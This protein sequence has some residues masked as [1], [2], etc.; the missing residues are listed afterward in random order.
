MKKCCVFLAEGFEET[1]AVA[2]IDIL[3]RGGISVEIVSITGKIEVCGAHQIT[4]LA[5]S[6]FAEASFDDADMLILPGGM[7]GA[8]NLSNF[9]PLKQLLVQFNLYQ[10]A[11]AAICAAPF[12]LGEIGLLQGKEATCYPGF[13]KQLL[14]ATLSKKKT[15]ISGNIITS[16]GI[17]SVLEFGIAIVKYLHGEAIAAQTAS[18]LLLE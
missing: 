9:A 8:S 11:I 4:I 1:E 5:D 18:A 2:I 14:G 12:I 3:R 16:V 7:P 15:V 13:E 10:K 6:L 17:I